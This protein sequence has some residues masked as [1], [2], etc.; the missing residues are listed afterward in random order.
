[1]ITFGRVEVSK[2]LKLH[3]KSVVILR[4]HIIIYVEY[5]P[6][7]RVIRVVYACAIAC[8]HILPLAIERQRVYRAKE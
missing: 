6:D 4:L 5:L 1:M 2:R 8:A 3:S 7:E